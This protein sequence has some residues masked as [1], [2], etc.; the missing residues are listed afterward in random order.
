MNKRNYYLAAGLMLTMA[1]S[2]VTMSFAAQGKGI[3][4]RQRAR[5]ARTAGIREFMRGLNITADQR[6]Q[7][8]TILQSHKA[9]IQQA[10]R[11]AMKARLDLDRDVAGAPGELANALAKAADL[12]KQIFEEIK[13]VLTPDQL[14]KAQKIRELREQRLQKQLDRYNSRIGG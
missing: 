5:I 4:M 8:K 12:K 3:G 14:A 6:A 2:M 11:D 10:R 9:Q 13:P 1:A 7:I